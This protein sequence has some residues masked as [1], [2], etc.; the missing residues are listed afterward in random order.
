M[1]LTAKNIASDM[2]RLGAMI[3]KRTRALEAHPLR[4]LLI[5]VS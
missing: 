2:E 4:A 1:T 3:E 5:R